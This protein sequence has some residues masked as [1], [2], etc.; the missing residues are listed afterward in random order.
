MGSDY[1]NGPEDYTF[2]IKNVGQDLLDNISANITGDGTVNHFDLFK[3]AAAWGSVCND[4]E[5]NPKADIT[6]DGTV[7]HFDLFKFAA[8][9]GRSC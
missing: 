5:Y 3:F 7:N 8:N 1:Y 6:D 9:W 2:E 4:T